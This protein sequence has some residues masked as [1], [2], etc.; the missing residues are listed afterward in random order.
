MKILHDYFTCYLYPNPWRPSL[1]AH[2]Q[3]LMETVWHRPQNLGMEEKAEA[4]VVVVPVSIG[5]DKS[6]VSSDVP[7]FL[8]C[9]RARTLT[10][11]ARPS[12]PRR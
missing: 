10:P 6:K 9:K 1:L 5:F 12:S 2:M 8:Q 11:D 7:S 3:T 4:I